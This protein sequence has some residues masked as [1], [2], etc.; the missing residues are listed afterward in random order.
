MGDLFLLSERQIP[1]IADLD[2]AYSLARR[3]RAPRF[4]PTGQGGL[5][6]G[7]EASDQSLG[8]DEAIDR[9]DAGRAQLIAASQEGE[10]AAN[11]VGMQMTD[12]DSLNLAQRHVSLDE[13][14]RGAITSVDQNRLVTHLQ[15][16]GRLRAYR[17]VPRTGAGAQGDEGG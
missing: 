7:N 16:M 10:Q 14:L 12:Q 11:M 6:T 9:H 17:I 4:R 1:T 2:Y 13:L 15:Q 3:Y 8:A 5:Q